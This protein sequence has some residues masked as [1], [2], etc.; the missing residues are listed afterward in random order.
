M[1][2][3]FFFL[4]FVTCLACKKDDNVVDPEIRIQ[5]KTYNEVIKLIDEKYIEAAI[6]TPNEEGALGRNKSA[7]FH[8]RF[9]LGMNTISDFAL[10]QE[11]IDALEATAK[12]IDYAFEHQRLEG[13]FELVVPEELQEL[14]E[15]LEA[16]LA[17][18]VA[19]FGS[20]LGLSLV[21]LSQSDW[22]N[23]STETAASKTAIEGYDSKFQLMLNY[24]K[25]SK[26]ML[27]EIDADAPNR[28]LFNAVAFYSLGLYLSDKDAKSIALDFA[29]KALLLQDQNQGYFIEGGGWDSSYN[30]VA[31][32][33][34][35]ELYMLLETSDLK[36]RL[37]NALEKSAQ[38]QVS[39]IKSSGEINTEGNT[40]VFEG[41]ESF[42]GSEKGVDYT[43]TA[44]S[45][46]YLSVLTDDPQFEEVAE[47]TLSFYE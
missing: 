26:A 21:S 20:S 27:F 38:W 32:Q 30:G 7:Y 31:N 45:L 4:A 5:A 18:G 41:G 13:D 19:F 23:S 9:Q 3:L 16:E 24:L 34:G 25:E 47:N 15:P 2:N 6:Q 11:R 14:G 37:K 43:K 39:R 8:V 17:S 29:E 42:L 28:L 35:L 10:T 12:A 40:R 46:L 36:N 33:L 1:K 44:K 22:Y